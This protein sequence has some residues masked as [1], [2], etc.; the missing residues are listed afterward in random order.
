V[1]RVTVAALVRD[2]NSRARLTDALRSEAPIRFCARLTE[3]L[4]MVE[5][6]LANLVV[7][8]HRD[9]DGSPTLPSIRRLRDEYPSVPIVVYLPM[10]AVVS[11]AVMEY[12]KAG[13]SQLV[14]QGVD[15]LKASLRSAVHTALD[16]VSAV[17]L[18]ADLEPLIP[19]TIVPFLRYCLEHARRDITV[20]EVAAAMGVHRKT[21][22]DRLKAARLPSPRAM[23]GWCRLLMAARM[24]DDPGRTVEQVALKLDFPSGA[25]LRNMFK[26]YTGL[27]TTEVRENGGVRCLLHAFKR[28]LA[29]VN[30][31]N[32][33]IA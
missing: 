33:P 4:A 3:V 25:A 11:G 14:F 9:Y 15:D 32:P 28:E 24:L 19:P 27:R 16:Q 30:A 20:E 13:V 7:V 10:S 5:A 26:R 23:I 29:A 1:T 6:G 18:G 22:V 31:G 17:A 8:D 12:A 2:P 21:L